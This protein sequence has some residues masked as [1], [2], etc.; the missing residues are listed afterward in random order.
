MV[1][2]NV[3]FT[4]SYNIQFASIPEGAEG[5]ADLIIANVEQMFDAHSDDFISSSFD[6]SSLNETV[7]QQAIESRVATECA[8]EAS[9]AQNEH[10]QHLLTE[11]MDSCYVTVTMSDTVDNIM[12]K[13]KEEMETYIG[14]ILGGG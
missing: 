14:S 13:I 9:V 2:N 6:D 7:I 12:Q 8:L 3:T 5:Y 11:M 10:V 1:M 4:I